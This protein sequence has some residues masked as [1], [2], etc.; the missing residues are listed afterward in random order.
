MVNY[1][2]RYSPNKSNRRSLID[3]GIAHKLGIRSVW[4]K[5]F[6]VS[7][8]GL[9]GSRFFSIPLMSLANVMEKPTSGPL[10]REPFNHSPRL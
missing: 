10:S 1:R 8:S 5:R 4:V 2:P 7:G 9:I 3:R 6:Q